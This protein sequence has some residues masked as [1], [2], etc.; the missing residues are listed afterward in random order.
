MQALS[1][2]HS[3]HYAVMRGATQNSVIRCLYKDYSG[4]LLEVRNIPVK[5]RSKTR[6]TSRCSRRAIM[7][8]KRDTDCAKRNAGN[9][10]W[11][12]TTRPV[13]TGRRSEE[14]TSELQS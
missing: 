5:K 13:F 1:A 7:N 14:H 4:S 9:R 11:I 8:T 3:C 10:T 2:G 12:L 6:Y